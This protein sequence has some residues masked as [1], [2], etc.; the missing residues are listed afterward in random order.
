MDLCKNKSIYCPLNFHKVK[1]FL[2]LYFLI[3]QLF[4][5]VPQ[6]QL[7]FEELFTFL[8]IIKAA[9]HKIDTEINI[10]IKSPSSI[11]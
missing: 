4:E 5:H 8:Y 1:A 2:L 3:E 6:L 9:K 7:P 10:S 11:K